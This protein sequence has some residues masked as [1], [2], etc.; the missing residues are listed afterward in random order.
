MNIV[1]A[2]PTLEEIT[3]AI[4]RER[5]YQDQQWGTIEQHPRTT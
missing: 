3:A 1:H 5:A 4:Q 2:H